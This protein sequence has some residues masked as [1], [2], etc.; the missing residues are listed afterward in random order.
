MKIKKISDDVFFGEHPN[1]IWEGYYTEGNVREGSFAVGERLFL[2]TFNEWFTTSI[3]KS[4]DDKEKIFK[5]KNSTYSYQINDC[6]NIKKRWE[7]NNSL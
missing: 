4:I 3:I 5:T 6:K 7:C 1:G 2:E